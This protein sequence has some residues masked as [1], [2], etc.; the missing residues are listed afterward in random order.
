MYVI[1]VM[2]ATR[3]LQPAHTCSFLN[4]HPNFGGE[5]LAFTFGV[6]VFVSL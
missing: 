2:A 6:C 1:I 4:P 5:F 3:T